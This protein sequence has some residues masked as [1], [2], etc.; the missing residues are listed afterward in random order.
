VACVVGWVFGLGST[1]VSFWMAFLLFVVKQE[2]YERV[3]VN[4]YIW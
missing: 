3:N 2:N 1:F 4:E